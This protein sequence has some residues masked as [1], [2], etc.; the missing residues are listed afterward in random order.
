M[1]ATVSDTS[2]PVPMACSEVANPTIGSTCS[3]T[4]SANAVLPGAIQTGRRTV[5]QME[6]VQV[7]DGGADGL[8]STAGN[9][10]FAVQGVFVP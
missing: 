1:A 6:R 3:V 4:T 5:W 7:F 10:L 8:A 9:G 2:F